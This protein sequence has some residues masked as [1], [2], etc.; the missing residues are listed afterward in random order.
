MIFSC[1]RTAFLPSSSSPPPIYLKIRGKK[2]A[3][4][5]PRA[6]SYHHRRR[7]TGF[8]SDHIRTC[9]KKTFFHPSWVSFPTF[10]NSFRPRTSVRDVTWSGSRSACLTSTRLPT[11]RSCPRPGWTSGSGSHQETS[12]FSGVFVGKWKKASSRG[13]THVVE[14][15]RCSWVE[16]WRFA[17]FP[18]FLPRSKLPVILQEMSRKH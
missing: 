5:C 10:L 12:Y 17:F 18:P 4:F 11:S 14:I 1:S 16:K 15:K 3:L 7:K 9:S 13:I 6:S 2:V 8:R